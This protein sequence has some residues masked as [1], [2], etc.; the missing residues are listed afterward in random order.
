MPS[1][2]ASTGLPSRRWLAAA[3]LAACLPC[4]S[5]LADVPVTERLSWEGTLAVHMTGASMAQDTNGNTNVDAA[6]EPALMPVTPADVPPTSTLVAA[7]L[8]W[9]GTQP[10]GPVACGDLSLRDD[11]I[12]LTVP[13][14][15]PATVVADDC[16]CSDGGAGTYDVWSCHADVTALLAAQGGN[17]IGTWTVTDYLGRISDGATDNASTALALVVNEPSL[18]PRRIVLHDGI[19]LFENT[20]RTI[21]LSGFTVDSTPAGS[22]TWYVLEGDIGGAGTESV[23]VDGTPGPAGPL[24]LADAIN[25]AGNPMNRTINTTSPPRV[26]VT[27]V[28]ID[29]FDISSALSPGDSGAGVTFT[30]G[31]D[32]WWLA[33]L[34]V[35]V[36]LFAPRFSEQSDKRMTLQVDADGNGAPTQ[37]DTVRCVIHLVNTGSEAGTIDVTDDIPPQVA[38]WVLVDGAGGTD[39]STPARLD[40]RGIR[41]ATGASADV[42]LDLVLGDNPDHSSMGNVACWSDPP[43]G[44]GAGCVTASPLIL[45]RDV[46]GDTIFDDDDN[47][48]LVPNTSQLDSDG[49]GRGDPCDSCDQVGSLPTA[50]P[51]PACPAE[52]VVLDATRLAF[53]ACPLSPLV[54]WRLAGS[55]VGSGPTLSQRLL[56][57]TPYEVSATCPTNP[58]CDWHGTLVVD[59]ERKPDFGGAIARDV[60]SCN[61]GIEITWPPAQ[62]FGPTGTGVYNVHRSTLSCADALASAPLTTTT[63]LRWFDATTIDG[64]TYYYLVQAEDDRL[65][66]RCGA[67]GPHGGRTAESCPV[68]V[69]EI[70]RGG[71]LPQPAPSGATLFVTHSGDGVTLSWPGARPLA[72]GEHLHL[73]KA[74]DRSQIFTLTNGEGYSAP[75]FSDTDTSSRLQYFTL[76]LADACEQEA[77]E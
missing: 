16:A 8:Y 53:S 11:A 17:G 2:R 39:A 77:A 28:D 35:E 3:V 59:V 51:S 5:L 75:S 61:A 13:G 70:A 23:S 7:I 49:D 44:G 21:D 33:A 68:P 45:R 22:L 31:G 9:A 32:K 29:R 12:T 58:A 60:A 65:T 38:S 50:S 73:W 54:E 64:V 15:S 41:V 40:V 74:R 25:P 36:D 72:P 4:R 46:D 20:S 52:N 66:T 37:G 67:S 24:T 26:G 48:L 18:P 47:C 6:V 19:E 1:S 14:G 34:A 76:R 27:G 71:T 42:V 30:A 56:L 55:L 69:T 57:T 10:Q 62:F 63:S 43:E